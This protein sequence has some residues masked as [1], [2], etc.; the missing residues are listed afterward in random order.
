MPAQRTDVD[1]RRY[2]KGAARGGPFGERHRLA[3]GGSVASVL[4][5]CILRPVDMSDAPA[6]TSLHRLTLHCC[7]ARIAVSASASLSLI[8]VAGQQ[9]DVGT[10]RQGASVV[11][12]NERMPVQRTDV[13]KRRYAKGRPAEVQWHPF[14]VVASFG[15]LTCRTHLPVRPYIAYLYIAYLYIAYP[16]IASPCIAVL[17]ASSRFLPVFS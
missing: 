5:R 10:Y 7:P 15:R 12:Q 17:H 13:D 16:Y 8:S 9:G 11:F 4:C 14:F 2:A 6:G 1:K 3:R